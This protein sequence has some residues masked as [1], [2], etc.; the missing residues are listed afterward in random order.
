MPKQRNILLVIADGEHARFVR[1]GRDNALHGDAAIDSLEAHKRSTEL[2]S[3]HPGASYHTGS[4]AHHAMTPRHDPH[5]LEKEKF[6]RLI[7]SQINASA[8]SKAFEELLIAAPAHVLAEIQEH[9]DSAAAARVIGT[10]HKDLVKTPDHE[11][12]PHFREWL[13][14]VHRPGG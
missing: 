1:P 13:E 7:A 5:E 11:L 10:L 9:L 14:P 8:A 4:T 3:D 12:W 6:G 2:G